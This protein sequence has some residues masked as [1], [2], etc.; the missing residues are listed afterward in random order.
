MPASL[1]G[2]APYRLPHC[3]VDF[4]FCQ[5]HGQPRR[6]LPFTSN[7]VVGELLLSDRRAPIPRRL[8]KEN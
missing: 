7:D 2:Q 3:G 1:I 6:L 8:A 4:G 5:K